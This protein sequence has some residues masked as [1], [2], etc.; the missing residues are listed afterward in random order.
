[1]EGSRHG[2]ASKLKKTHE[3]KSQV[4]SK[5]NGKK[6][7]GKSRAYTCA[8]N[9]PPF[10]GDAVRDHQILWSVGFWLSKE[11]LATDWYLRSRLGPEG[12]EFVDLELLCG[13]PSLTAVKAKPKRVAYLVQQKMGTDVVM[14]S[15][16]GKR[17]RRTKPIA[18]GPG[19]DQSSI[20]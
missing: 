11:N 10:S 15:K 16:D 18:S 2:A 5:T 8:A 17:I 6:T 4:A 9:R 20:C 3:M 7:K 19:G 14:L 12:T 13:F 1:M